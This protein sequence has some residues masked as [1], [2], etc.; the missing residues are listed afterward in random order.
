M[1]ICREEIFGPVQ[2]IQKVK[3]MDD[4]IA[5]ANKYY[6][7]CLENKLFMIFPFAE[8][9]MDWLLQFSLKISVR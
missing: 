5:R 8:T 3:N 9:L 7:T 2:A 6:S 4:A 1:K